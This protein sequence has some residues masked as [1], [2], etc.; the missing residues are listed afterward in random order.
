MPPDGARA[1]AGGF[2]GPRC[3]CRHQDV[4]RWQLGGRP[5]TVSFKLLPPGDLV[6]TGNSSPATGRQSGI[7]TATA[8]R[9]PDNLTAAG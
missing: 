9:S 8:R 7:L 1:A 6:D 4:G 3:V 2:L 5:A